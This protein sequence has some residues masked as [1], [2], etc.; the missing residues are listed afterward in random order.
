VNDLISEGYLKEDA[1]TKL[2]IV[3]G[4]VEGSEVIDYTGQY[5]NGTINSTDYIEK[6]NNPSFG[7]KDSPDWKIR[8]LGNGTKGEGFTLFVGT[9][10]ESEEGGFFLKAG[11]AVT[12]EAVIEKL[13]TLATG[14]GTSTPSISYERWHWAPKN[15]D[16]ANKPGKVVVY[17]GKLY[18]YARVGWIPLEDSKDAKAADATAA[19]IA[20]SNK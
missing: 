10:E 7:Y 9:T 17:N 1:K 13:N 14:S 16:S 11:S 20:A 4:K 12:D 18:V 2:R 6:M 15:V 5:E 3:G 19:F 8:G